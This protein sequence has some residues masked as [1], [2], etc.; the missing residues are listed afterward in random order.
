MTPSSFFSRK[1]IIAHSDNNKEVNIMKT[2]EV[3]AFMDFL[4]QRLDDIITD[5]LV[6]AQILDIE[7]E[8]YLK[9]DNEDEKRKLADDIRKGLNEASNINGK[10]ELANMIINFINEEA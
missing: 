5:G 6:T 8:G 9:T 3:K 1:L 7:K 2:I 4:E 10:L